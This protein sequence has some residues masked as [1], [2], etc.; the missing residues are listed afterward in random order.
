MKKISY[1][2]LMAL[3]TFTSVK[4][5][6][7]IQFFE[8]TFKDALAKAKSEKKL[9]FLDCYATW[10][11]PCKWMAAHVFTNDSV[12]E[13][14]NKN[15]INVA[16]DMEKGEGLELAKTYSVKNYP[17]YIWMD[18]NGKQ[19]QRSVGS[20]S[21]EAF[22]S[23]ASDA[24][25]PQRNLAHLKEQYLADNRKPEFLLEYAQA[26]KTAY[27]MS[28]QVIADEYFR[29]VSK[30]ELV[31][32]KNW[33]TVLEFTPNIDSYIYSYI[34]KNQQTF[35]QR[36]GKDSV[37]HV[38]DDLALRSV[39]YAGQQKDSALFEK[40][41]AILKQSSNTE[42]LKSMAKGELNYYKRTGNWNKY[43]ST[44]H[45]YV[46]KYFFNDANM[47]NAVCWTYFQRIDD[48]KQLAEAEKWI[49]QSVKLENAYYNTDTY[50]NILHKEGKHKEA[51]E[52]TKH[53]IELAKKAGEDY[54]STQE[55]LNEIQKVQ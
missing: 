31:N 6:Q 19:V 9:L 36:Y 34:S 55:L 24:M 8:G 20:T 50:A 49:A 32:E 18:E 2:T 44:A 46:P 12:A 47:L 22:I 51:L 1:L 39:D 40:A 53:S 13:F 5:E 42:T 3:L 25:N 26:L 48:K 21:A 27:D 14:F 33:N 10:C 28:Y 43:A 17:T 38:L 52:M 16:S 23:I 45:E 30:E 37:Q 54:S 11:G 35:N 7:G 29:S 41:T 4:A 15:F